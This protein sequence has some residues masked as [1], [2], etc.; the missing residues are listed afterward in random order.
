M[1]EFDF[2]PI[3]RTVDA[4]TGRG[5]AINF[6]SLPVHE[7]L[8]ALLAATNRDEFV[9]WLWH[10]LF[11]PLF[12]W[13]WNAR[14]NKFDWV[15]YP[16]NKANDPLNVEAHWS[17]F[18]GT[19]SG[20][21]ATHHYTRGRL[22]ALGETETVTNEF[23]QVMLGRNA[24]FLQLAF[25]AEPA[26]NTSLLRAIIADGFMEVITKA[27]ARVVRQELSKKQ[28]TFRQV[29]YVFEYE[30]AQLS[31]PL[32][33]SEIETLRDRYDMRFQGDVLVITHIT[34]VIS[35]EFAGRHVEVTMDFTGAPPTPER[36]AQGVI[37]LVELLTI[38]QDSRTILMGIPQFFQIDVGQLTQQVKEAAEQRLRNLDIRTLATEAR[39][40]KQARTQGR[41]DW[42]TLPLVRQGH[43]VDLLSH[44]FAE[45]VKIRL[46]EKGQLTQKVKIKDSR[47][48]IKYREIRPLNEVASWPIELLQSKSRRCRFCSTA[49]DS[50]FPPAEARVKDAFSGDFTDIE[51]VGFSGD[52]CPMCRIYALNNKFYTATEKAQGKSGA[53]KAY[54]GSFAL[55]VPSSHFAYAE[56]NVPVE[57]PPLDAG[58]RFKGPLQRA[59]V[60]LQE[61]VLFNTISRRIVGEMWGQLSDDKTQPLPLPYCGGILLTENDAHQVR[62]LF[63]HIEVLFSK[64]VLWV[65]PFKLTVQPTVEI[66]FEMAVNDRKQHLTKHTYLKTSSVI[67]AVDPQSK[68][69]LLVDNGLQL[70]VGPQ[71]FADRKRLEELL[72]GIK[73]LKRRRNWLLAVL[74]GNDPATATA[75]AFY[76]QATFWHAENTFWAAQVGYG[77][78]AE[79]WRAYEEVQKEIKQIVSRYPLLVEFFPNPR[80]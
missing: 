42:T 27:V 34:P 16:N 18:T 8:T 55:L 4:S 69:T 68:F 29:R 65:Y 9:A 33:N 35:P 61:C 28:P 51:H 56:K 6:A 60:T 3:S 76:D 46:I 58:G 7:A 78:P 20:L 59:T 25:L 26:S 2:G 54:R 17:V 47:G 23:D 22:L 74:Q 48:H 44:V 73:G 15:H 19:R 70:E 43:D 5:D 32:V 10:D 53:R 31:S 50:V 57:Q 77:S 72:S 21:V 71:F 12:W 14:R 75:E 24:R 30:Q 80:R 37:T 39:L 36:F 40:K 64:V 13:R 49:F 41:V 11:K 38:Y 1:M 45:Q 63:D 66:A 52:I 67:V 79:Q 62:N